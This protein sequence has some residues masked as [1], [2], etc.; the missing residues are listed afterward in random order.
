[1]QIGGSTVG[2]PGTSR[3]GLYYSRHLKTVKGL[4]SG[5]HIV[6]PSQNGILW[7]RKG[8]INNNAGATSV[9]PGEVGLMVTLCPP[10]WVLSSWRDGSDRSLLKINANS[11]NRGPEA[12]S[13][14]STGLAENC[15][16]SRMGQREEL[17]T[18]TDTTG[19]HVGRGPWEWAPFLPCSFL[20][21]H[22]HFSSLVTCSN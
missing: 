16:R 20:I 2:D 10:F 12:D 17:D 5:H 14:A 21:V 1:M 18:T 6:R 22:I 13:K 3:N 7:E 4:I 11:S 19:S 9:K 8:A 15:P